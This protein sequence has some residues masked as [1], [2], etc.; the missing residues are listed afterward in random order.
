MRKRARLRYSICGSSEDSGHMS[1]EWASVKT[2]P[3]PGHRAARGGRC[4][5]PARAEPALD[6]PLKDSRARI[7]V[8]QISSLQYC[9]PHCRPR[10]SARP[11][12]STRSRFL[13]ASIVRSSSS[14]IGAVPTPHRPD[15]ANY[16]HP[17]GSVGASNSCSMSTRGGLSVISFAEV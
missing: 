7:R 2:I 17:V 12:P 1:S 9:T 4:A 14:A 11:R 8:P 6:A 16:S 15:I 3:G 13:L 10:P 5:W